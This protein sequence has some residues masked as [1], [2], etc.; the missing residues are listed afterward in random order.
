MSLV[1]LNCLLVSSDG[2]T[3]SLASIR[4]S[5]QPLQRSSDLSQAKVSM[6]TFSQPAIS[7][8][9]LHTLSSTPLCPPQLLIEYLEG[10]KTGQRE[11]LTLTDYSSISAVYIEDQLVWARRVLPTETDSNNPVAW[12]AKVP[13]ST[14]MYFACMYMYVCMTCTL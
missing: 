5:T 9:S 10:L 6:E 3:I 4:A 8:I 1:G 2:G 13:S 7:L 11:W 14:C 12:P